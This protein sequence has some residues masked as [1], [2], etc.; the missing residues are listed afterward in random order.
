MR[1]ETPF[2]KLLGRARGLRDDQSG[3]VSAIFALALVPVFGL[4]GAAVDYS[5]GNATRTSMQ[6]AVDATAL[7]L[8]KSASSLTSDQL[9]QKATDSFNALYNGSQTQSGIQ[10]S[11]QYDATAKS[12]T[13]SATGSIK[14]DF[15]GVMGVSN[16]GVKARAV[17]V[18]IGEGTACVLSLNKTASGAAIAQGSTTVN[19][20]GCSLYDNSAN[21][22]AL[23]VGGSARL[24][25]L[26]VGVVGG[27]SGNTSIT[28][29]NGVN[30]GVSPIP[31]PYA[32]LTIPPYSGC[33]DHNFTA[34][35]KVTIN[36][37]VY[38]GG[39]KLNAGADVTL[40]PGIYYIDRGDLTVN[41]GATLSG[42]GVTIIFTSSTNS[43]WP[44][45]SI[46]G[47][48]TVSLTPPIDGPTAGVSM[49]ADRNIPVGTTFGFNGGATQYI[50]GAIYIPTGDVTFAGGAGSTSS[51][52]KLIADT[53]TFTGTSNFAIDC[54]GYGT[55]A[56][57][58]AGVRLAS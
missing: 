18:V 30:T 46:N 53:I 38:C 32:K 36:P 33:N 47:G 2:A 22:S 40:N 9:S 20:S 19:L 58:P 8:I 29:T 10:V 12:V 39:M 31:D 13:M 42:T 14:T 5:R 45:A 17:A 7:N 43:S 41:G 27:I 34:K 51:C 28:T 21:A 6:A 49:F 56:F 25:A 23:T 11:A 55:K 48:A 3:N 26:S 37:G 52:T 57:G 1:I 16:L 24:S 35:T 15:M 4:I 54:K 44:S 50:G